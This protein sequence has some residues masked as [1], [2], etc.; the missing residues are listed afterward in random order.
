MSTTLTPRS[1]PT[2]RECSRWAGGDAP[3]VCR[4][5]S[6]SVGRTLQCCSRRRQPGWAS[7]LLQDDG[8]VLSVKYLNLTTALHLPQEPLDETALSILVLFQ[9]LGNGEGVALLPQ[10]LP[11]Q[12]LPNLVVDD[13]PLPRVAG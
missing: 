3:P 4:D 6:T 9:G 10:P 5:G 1:P 13:I 7:L 12:P 8:L 11:L 2:H